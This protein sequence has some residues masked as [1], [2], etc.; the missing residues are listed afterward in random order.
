MKRRSLLEKV[1]NRLAIGAGVSVF[2][3]ELRESYAAVSSGSN[4]TTKPPRAGS[5][6][7]VS[8]KV[9][10]SRYV[11]TYEWTDRL[12]RRWRSEFALDRTVYAEAVQEHHGYLGGFETA[13][14]SRDVERFAA[15]LAA[16]DLITEDADRPIPRTVRFERAIEFVRSLE[17]M[18]D[19]DSK[20]VPDYVRTAEE[21][22]VDGRG[23]CEDLA[24][25][26]I[27]ILSHPPFEYRT[28]MVIL[29]GHM[30]VGVHKDDLPAAYAD[31]P[32]L[33][34]NRYVAI[35]SVTSRPIGS[36]QDKPVLLIY[37]DGVEYVDRSAIA[38][39]TGD[40]LRNPSEFQ[41]IAD[42]RG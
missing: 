38:D 35:E 10:G 14:T 2:L 28:A 41:T 18:T 33:P 15:R 17:Y 3:S 7:L 29:P 39:A 27:G 13:K 9:T 6:G 42:L 34:G 8:R 30:L 31:T 24:Y 12:K 36:F 26:L 5:R 25:L 21:T 19:I 16:A 20:G 4:A 37:N 22:L 23:D 32:T 1:I 11:M 40:I